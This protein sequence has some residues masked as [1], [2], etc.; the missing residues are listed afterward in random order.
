MQIGRSAGVVLDGNFTHESGDGAGAY[1]F[2]IVGE[3]PGCKARINLPRDEGRQITI[4]F[5]SGCLPK[6]EPGARPWVRFSFLE[7][8]ASVHVDDDIVYTTDRLFSPRT[9]DDTARLYLG[10]RIA[11]SS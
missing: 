7:T 8:F 11:P 4:R 1:P 2:D 6:A 9:T 10:S 5:G 3:V